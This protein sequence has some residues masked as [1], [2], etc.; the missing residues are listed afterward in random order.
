MSVNILADDAFI[1][2][3]IQSPEEAPSGS[4]SVRATLM[5]IGLTDESLGA[6][7]DTVN[8]L[9]QLNCFRKSSEHSAQMSAAALNVSTEMVPPPPSK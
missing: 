9:I 7:T 1:Q 5:K 2:Q 3:N 6:I 4:L 8:E